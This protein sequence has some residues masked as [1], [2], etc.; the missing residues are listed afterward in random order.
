MSVEIKKRTGL[1]VPEGSNKRRRS[2]I[3][4]S[5]NPTNDEGV[6][7]CF[8]KFS[9]S[10]YVSLAPAH[11]NSP[12]NGLKAQHLDPLIMTYLPKAGGVVLSYSN[13]KL[14]EDNSS[15]DAE[16]NAITVSKIEGSSPFTFLWITV[17]FLIW[18]PQV[19]DVLEGYI[20]MQTASHLGLLIH[21]TFNASIKKYNIPN[22]WQF[23]PSQEDEIADAATKSFGYW[24]DENESKIEGKLKFTVKT[25]HTSGKV[26]SVEGTLI[27]PGAERDAQ[28]IFR[29]RRS[30]TSSQSGKNKHKKFGDDDSIPTLSEIAEP[31]D[32]DEF[33]AYIKESDNENIDEDSAIVNK[34]DSDEADNSD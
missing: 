33:P 15:E 23:I 17:D 8:Y 6:S 7:Q 4:V 27:K 2:I 34:S 19:G 16:G 11:L 25:I 14:S 26:V 20:Y 12:I 9:T 24:V 18:R 29:E 28:P 30:S 10:L 3:P 31:K 32:E 21:D 5:S 1:A 13:I 22:N